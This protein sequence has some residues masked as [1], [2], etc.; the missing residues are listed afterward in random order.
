MN[1]AITIVLTV[2]VIIPEVLAADWH[3]SGAR[4]IMLPVE[5]YYAYN[6]KVIWDFEGIM[7]YSPIFYGY[8]RYVSMAT[9]NDVPRKVY[10][11]THQYLKKF[12]YGFWDNQWFGR[13]QIY[14]KLK[15]VNLCLVS[16]I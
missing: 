4:K 14:L 11:V 3:G 13:N 9:K 2:F 8:Y 5:K 6:L 12:S 1:F 10:R 7:R 16:R 15:L